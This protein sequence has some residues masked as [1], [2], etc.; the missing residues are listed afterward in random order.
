MWWSK[1]TDLDSTDS[2]YGSKGSCGNDS[3]PSNSGGVGVEATDAAKA[4]T[5]G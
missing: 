5:E 3:G 1:S 2:R 4:T